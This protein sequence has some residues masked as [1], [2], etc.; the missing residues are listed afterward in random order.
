MSV[1]RNYGSGVRRSRLRLRPPKEQVKDENDT[2]DVFVSQDVSLAN[3]LTR[4][5]ESDLLSM[6]ATDDGLSTHEKRSNT[7]YTTEPVTISN[8]SSFCAIEKTSASDEFTNEI[9]SNLSS[10][11]M[12]I[13]LAPVGSRPLADAYVECDQ[14]VLDMPGSN[15]SRSQTLAV[16]SKTVIDNAFAM[17][18]HPTEIITE[19]DVSTNLPPHQCIST[20]VTTRALSR[21][22]T[23]TSTSSN[24][25]TSTGPLEGDMKPKKPSA[26]SACTPTNV[27]PRRISASS[28]I[29]AQKNKAV[30]SRD[31]IK[32]TQMKLTAFFKSNTS[33]PL[34]VCDVSESV[35]MECDNLTSGC[36][37]ADDRFEILRLSHSPKRIKLRSEVDGQLRVRTT[38]LIDTIVSKK[39]IQTHTLTAVN[40]HVCSS[41][42]PEWGAMVKKK[43]RL[44]YTPSILTKESKTSL[45]SV[46]KGN[47]SSFFLTPETT[48]EEA[49]VS[50]TRTWIPY[51]RRSYGHMYENHFQDRRP[52][53]VGVYNT[54]RIRAT[55]WGAKAPEPPPS[56]VHT[57]SHMHVHT[58][59]NVCSV[60]EVTNGRAH[61][62]N[63]N[64]SQTFQT[65]TSGDITNERRDYYSACLVK[66]MRFVLKEAVSVKMRGLLTE[67]QLSD[68]QTV[69]KMSDSDLR[70]FVSLYRTISA[71]RWIPLRR[72]GLSVDCLSPLNTAGLVRF[73]ASPVLP[74]LPTP[75]AGI[76]MSEFSLLVNGLTVSQL[77]FAAKLANLKPTRA[78]NGDV[79]ENQAKK[80]VEMVTGSQVNGI[81]RRGGVDGGGSPRKADYVR[82]LCK[83]ASRF[84]PFL[85]M[86][87]SQ[88][89]AWLIL[90][91]KEIGCCARLTGIANPLCWH[92]RYQSH[93]PVTTLP[94][95]PQTRIQE[96]NIGPSHAVVEYEDFVGHERMYANKPVGVDVGVG[97]QTDTNTYAHIRSPRSLWSAQA[98]F[99]K[100]TT[101]L[102]ISDEMELYTSSGLADQCYTHVHR[103][104]DALIPYMSVNIVNEDITPSEINAFRAVHSGPC[105]HIC[106]WSRVLCRV[107]YRGVGLLQREKRYSEARHYLNILLQAGGRNPSADAVYK[108]PYLWGTVM[109]GDV[110]CRYGRNLEHLG[111]TREALNVYERALRD[112][113]VVG[114][115]RIA[116]QRSVVKLSKPPYRW[117]VPKFTTLS[118]QFPKRTVVGARVSMVAANGKT[119]LRWP[120]PINGEMGS[121]EEYA[122]Q[123]MIVTL[124]SEPYQPQRQW[125][126]MHSENGVLMTLFGL[127]T[128]DVILDWQSNAMRS[129]TQ[130]FTGLQDMPA[131]LNDGLMALKGLGSHLMGYFD[132]LVSLCVGAGSFTESKLDGHSTSNIGK[133]VANGT[134]ITEK[135]IGPGTQ[136]KC[137]IGPQIVTSEQASSDY[138]DVQFDFTEK[139]SLSVCEANCGEVSLRQLLTDAWTAHYGQQCKGVNWKR[140]T[141]EELI[142]I[143]EGLGIRAVASAC[144]RLATGF[145]QW[146]GGLPDL[147]LW[148]ESVPPK[149]KLVEVKGPGDR[150]SERQIAWLEYLI[151]SGVDVEVCYVVEKKSNGQE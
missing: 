63:K 3:S 21:K 24:A 103:A 66:N 27:T 1:K 134:N 38:S 99:D 47:L 148:C 143:A 17:N 147:L 52:P 25:S 11:S 98:D 122:M 74:S 6:P 41:S 34:S 15:D 64:P 105:G 13:P 71:T 20:R 123:S 112:E 91:I 19:E 32:P 96:Q 93:S 51:C 40:S 146:A 59:T 117:S 45:S 101:A 92:K 126:G 109:L 130:F 53:G 80:S 100:F 42:T 2:P 82:V 61:A 30:V 142:F 84:W 150:L 90:I 28:V 31:R 127:L 138:N 39:S 94:Q 102:D 54:D 95:Y 10:K 23:S 16:S 48:G 97:E 43:K 104:A 76:T 118:M 144:K 83:H 69:I 131:S 139:A 108:T 62:Q 26:Q 133:S 137:M 29:H 124:N 7:I 149:V 145:E 14:E 111:S 125:K 36:T 49:S 5:P 56:S 73:L 135:I 132:G 18:V 107:V 50:D 128:W 129:D 9:I 72:K 58:D 113:Y 115:Q 116:I 89:P 75:D 110:W 77:Q 37:M 55:R 46:S 87:K 88:L 60:T 141:L 22:L 68:I 140:N 86:K 33:S 121:V 70:C 114:G 79:A 120:C 67:S 44:S 8:P 151:S 57:L 85:H 106:E 35:S 81:K 4:V 12:H 119:S 65:V 136:E 78:H